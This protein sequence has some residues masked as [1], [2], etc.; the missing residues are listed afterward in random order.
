MPKAISHFCNPSSMQE[1]SPTVAVRKGRLIF[2]QS[3]PRKY[4]CWFQQMKSNVHFSPVPNRV[5]YPPRIVSCLNSWWLNEERVDDAYFPVTA[6]SPFLPISA[7]AVLERNHF[8]RHPFS[9]IS[10]EREKRAVCNKYILNTGKRY[11]NNLKLKTNKV[12]GFLWG[13][14]VSANVC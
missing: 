10:A 4:F 13:N 7:Y 8:R 2:E 11:G 14:F 9:S 12:L 1:I 5:F 3:G 6:N